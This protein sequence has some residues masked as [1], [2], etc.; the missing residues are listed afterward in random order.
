MYDRMMSTYTDLMGKLDELPAEIADN[1]DEML[2]LKRSIAPLEDA[3]EQRRIALIFT[4]GGWAALGKNEGERSM[5]EKKMLSEDKAYQDAAAALA[6]L[7][8][9]I[10][11]TAQRI[12][13]S[14]R[15]Y[16]AVCYQARLTAAFMGFL[17][18]AGVT[19]EQP[20]EAPMS[21][22]EVGL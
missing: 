19:T 10:D 9:D 2:Q 13:D 8:I 4:A 14:E 22:E 3:L 21:A 6:N 15:Q 18:G 17:A 1:E 20:M 11:V 5:A 7:R 12:K 16:G